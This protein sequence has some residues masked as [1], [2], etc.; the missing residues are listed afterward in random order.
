MGTCS[1]HCDTH[2]CMHITIMCKD[3]I[4]SVELTN[5]RTE[6]TICYRCTCTPV[7]QSHRDNVTYCPPGVAYTAIWLKRDG[8]IIQYELIFERL[9]CTHGTV[10]STARMYRFLIGCIGL[11]LSTCIVKG[12][13]QTCKTQQGEWVGAGGQLCVYLVVCVWIASVAPCQILWSIVHYW[14]GLCVL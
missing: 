6:L 3:W 9:Q 13:Q 1:G 10:T 14:L 5:T 2:T 8:L 4:N 11:S 12:P 7:F